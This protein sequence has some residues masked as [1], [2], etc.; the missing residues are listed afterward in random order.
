MRISGLLSA[1]LLQIKK[2]R[3]NNKAFN[4]EN[5]V[6]VSINKLFDIFGKSVRLDVF[7]LAFCERRRENLC[8][9]ISILMKFRVFDSGEIGHQ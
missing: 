7:S 1:L 2:S 9:A 8:R 4:K 6:Y 5:S 3:C